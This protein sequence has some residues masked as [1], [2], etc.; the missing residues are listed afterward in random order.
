MFEIAGQVTQVDEPGIS[1]KVVLQDLDEYVG[2][3]RG[4]ERDS[5]RLKIQFETCETSFF[6]DA[7]KDP[8]SLMEKL[9]RIPVGRRIG[10]LVI[11]EG[12]LKRVFLRVIE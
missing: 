7:L 9:N 3:Y 8:D 1:R 4:Y 6:M 10:L 11:E 5:L 2:V 12:L